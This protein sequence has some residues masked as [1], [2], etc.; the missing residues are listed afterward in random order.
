MKKSDFFGFSLLIGCAISW[1]LLLQFLRYFFSYVFYINLGLGKLNFVSFIFTLCFITPLILYL[2]PEKFDKLSVL[3]TPILALIC[4]LVI[5]FDISSMMNVVIS[6]LG[7]AFLLIW[8]T[9]IFRSRR[10]RI[11]KNI[12]SSFILAL[13]ID[14]VLRM[15]GNSFDITLTIVGSI[16]L[17]IIGAIAFTSIIVTYKFE[18]KTEEITVNE[19]ETS[20]KFFPLFILSVTLI[21]VIILFSTIL[22][23]PNV[24]IRWKIDT[25]STNNTEF[26]IIAWI[27]FALLGGI[28]LARKIVHERILNKVHKGYKMIA[29]ITILGLIILFAFL[30]H[31]AFLYLS[32]I[33]LPLLLLLLD[34]ISLESFEKLRNRKKWI[35]AFTL[36]AFIGLLMFLFQMFAFNFPAI[37]GGSL[38]KDTYPFFVILPAILALVSL[39]LIWKKGKE[40]KLKSNIT[41][42]SILVGILLVGLILA[43]SL[44]QPRLTSIDTAPSTIKVCT[45]NIFQGFD[46]NGQFNYESVYETL[47]TI[48]AD[49]IGL[50]ET[51][52]GRI[53]NLNSDIVRYLATRLDFYYYQAPAISESVY[54]IAIL[55]RYPI[56]ETSLEPLPSATDKRAYISATIDLGDK[57]INVIVT[58]FSYDGSNIIDT[59]NRFDQANTIIDS[60]HALNADLLIGDF[61]AISNLT[62]YSI[63]RTLFNDS[64]LT[65]YPSG[66]NG[67]SYNGATSEEYRIDYIFY[68]NI[69]CTA[70]EVITESTASDHK[71]V[72]AIFSI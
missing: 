36:S 63:I 11:F 50:Q 46:E 70:C 41:I 9:L 4:R 69:I 10:E 6:S 47:S 38:L 7:I 25:F 35:G 71:P 56:I 60:T 68:T 34:S 12:G 54:G 28:F 45:Y 15:I 22:T 61:N 44:N 8:V 52:T 58:H 55:S 26:W 39:V 51:E 67:T 33:S 57:E 65:V 5:I 23:Y 21:S 30:Q 17:I 31:R 59:D 32:L 49:I 14:L 72:V 16:V 20:G 42:N 3:I 53:T 37:P 18:D 66:I 19:K 13:M 43:T 29:S 40:I 1:L 27:E 2:I 62:E 24:Q 64:W 48:D